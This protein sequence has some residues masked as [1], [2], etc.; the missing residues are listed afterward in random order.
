MLLITDTEALAEFCARC[1]EHPYVTVDTEFLR[2]RTYWPQLCLVQMAHPGGEDDGSAALI[3]PL[4]EGMDLAPLFAL[5]KAPDVTKVFHAA[6]QDLEIFWHLGGLVPAPLVDTQVG[7]MVCGYGDQAGYETLVRKIC[8]LG[9]DK[10]SR[11]TDWT[12]RPLSDKQLAYAL[13]DV[14]HLRAIHEA[15]EAELVRTGRKA[16]VGEEMAVLS[17]PETY[18]SDPKEAW[19]R[20]KTRSTSP[21][22]LAVARALAEWR[23]RRAQE[24][25]VPRNR[26]MKDDALLEVASN[27]PETL[28]ELG[29]SRLLLREARKGDAAK[30]ILEAVKAG[31]AAPETEAPAAAGPVRGAK[32]ASGALTDLLKVLLK[33]RAEDLRVAPKLLASS[34]DL[35][36]IASEDDPDVP[37]MTGWRREAFGELALQLKRGE[38]ALSADRDGI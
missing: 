4:A 7:A 5:M 34:D 30:E 35:A 31:L 38:I 12:Q 18:R 2:E 15:L 14:T 23:E 28:E 9:L 27:R 26:L 19:R 16:W 17:D 25:D 6:R 36:R 20:L 8:K 21:K 37:A 24:K 29:R 1:A 22:F 11:F 13:A 3:D 33:S 32:P 10:S